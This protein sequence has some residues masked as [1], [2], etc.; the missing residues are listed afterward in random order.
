MAGILGPLVLDFSKYKVFLSCSKG[1]WLARCSQVRQG[2]RQEGEQG[3]S[4]EAFLT[5]SGGEE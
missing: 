3:L 2:N 1:K 5:L 4:W